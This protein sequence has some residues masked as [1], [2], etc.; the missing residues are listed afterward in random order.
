MKKEQE[1]QAFVLN[2]HHQ[3]MRMHPTPERKL[4][5]AGQTYESEHLS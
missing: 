2:A 4:F 1:K 3:P 5:P